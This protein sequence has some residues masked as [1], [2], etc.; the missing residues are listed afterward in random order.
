MNKNEFIGKAPAV[1]TI[2][3]IEVGGKRF[4]FHSLK[5][6][7]DSQY[8]AIRQFPRVY[9][10]M[11]ENLLRN[12]GEVG[13]SEEHIH[14]LAG[15]QPGTQAFSIPFLPARVLLQD[16]T[17]VPVLNDLTS[18]RSAIQRRGLDPSSI[19][20]KLPCDL[21][22]DHSVQVDSYGCAEAQRINEELEFTRN[23]ERF[24]FLR[25]CQ[26]AYPGLRVIPPG[27]GIIHQVNLEYLA[28]IVA[29][30]HAENGNMWAFPDS[31]FGTDSHTTMI[32][33]LGVLGW[34][35]GGIEA[36]SA[37]LGIASEMMLPE[38]IGLKLTGSLSESLT[39]ADITLH[40]NAYLRKQGVVGKIIEVFGPALSL[41]GV[42]ERAAIAN[43]T[44]ESGATAT[45][46]P[47]DEQTLRYFQLTGR[48][49]FQTA[50]VEAY[51]RAQ[52]L[53]CQPQDETPQYEQVFEFDL[54]RL[55]RVIAGPSRPQDLIALDKV[56]AIVNEKTTARVKQS[57]ISEPGRGAD[58]VDKLPPAAVVLAAITA[59]TNTSS[60]VN[61]LAA[62]LLAKHAVERGLRV[63]WWVKTVLA[64][65]SRVV[66]EYLY[67]SGLLPFLEKLGFYVAGY[68]C[69]V[70]IGNSGPL[71]DKVMQALQIQNTYACAVLSGN[72]NFEGR[73]H[74]AAQASFLASPPLVLAYA[75]AGRM[76]IDLINQPLGV[77][78]DGKAVLLDEIWPHASEI[79]EAAGLINPQLYTNLY[80]H[81]QQGS[82]T[83]RGLAP[84]QG[85]IFPWSDSSV[86]LREPPFLAEPVV[87]L[88]AIHDIEEARAIAFFGDGI[89]TDHISPAGNVAKGTPAWDYLLAQGVQE[90]DLNAFGTYRANHHVMLRGIFANTRLE[91][92]LA[93]G[94]RGGFTKFLP[95]GEIMRV[96]DAAEKYRQ[97]GVPLIV[98]AGQG[99]GTGSSRDWA[100]KGLA[101]LGVRAVL[102]QSFE[103]IHR[104]NL[105]MMGVL[106]LQFLAGDS[107]SELGL[108]GYETYTIED[109]RAVQAG[110]STLVVR[111]QREDRK[112]K[113]FS[114][115]CRIDT[116]LELEYWKM[117]GILPYILDRTT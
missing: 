38:V 57:N 54:S 20:F 101:L 77:D 86:Y 75:I 50:L 85:S 84:A 58:A 10:V 88:S 13:F 94:M 80:A 102:A 109:L 1:D 22:I 93:D 33:G 17:G 108:S 4:Q 92:K 79:R 31:V 105:V 48:S 9:R 28:D 114:M 61:M 98:L 72:R 103:R 25:W 35:V 51:Y 11:L 45:Y 21:V 64:P 19:D 110:G 76:D 90:K 106:P 44:P 15:W 73:I 111:A 41:L 42:E 49:D 5:A 26:N 81:I 14:Q 43:M 74:P 70:C 12:R 36:L 46:F 63:P 104:A 60:A 16:F 115:I 40:I 95:S 96:Y 78:R 7:A 52:E 34:G 66:T 87:P 29:V 55:N 30:K 59:C 97:A 3:R 18:F 113:V 68:G 100:A 27:K 107:P 112:E 62:G 23:R 69:T 32:N 99:F 6:L 117:G 67:R 83:W 24:E 56:G 8:P 89:T 39:P 91:N 53:F 82:H 2:R 47:V 65:G 116:A 37:L 71:Q